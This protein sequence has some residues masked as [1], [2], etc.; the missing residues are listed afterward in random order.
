LLENYLSIED[1]HLQQSCKN[2]EEMIRGTGQLML[3]RGYINVSY[4]EAMVTAK[5]TYGAYMVIAPGVALLHARPEDGVKQTGLVFFTSNEDILFDS[6]ND[7][8]RLGIGFAAKNPNEHLEILAD[9]SDLLQ[10]E[11]AIIKISEFMAGEEQNLIDFLINLK[12]ED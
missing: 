2:W 3:E 12:F 10:N 7:P 9:L 5:Q 4:I 8:V 1:L 6:E 11:D